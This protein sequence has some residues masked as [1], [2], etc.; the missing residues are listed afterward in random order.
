VAK[1]VKDFGE[2]VVNKDIDYIGVRMKVMDEE[3]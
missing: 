3:E 2:V 1:N